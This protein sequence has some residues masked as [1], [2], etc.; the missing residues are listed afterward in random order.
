MY[1]IWH[2]KYQIRFYEL[3]S[4]AVYNNFCVYKYLPVFLCV[5]LKQI[6]FIAL[7]KPI[8]ESNMRYY[9]LKITNTV[10]E[11][12]QFQFIYNELFI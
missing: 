8:N 6:K 12:S 9:L 5:K 7:F 2:L 3:V 11:N 10:F 1:V 4:K